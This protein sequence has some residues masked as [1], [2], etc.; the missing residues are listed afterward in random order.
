[1]AAPA[2]TLG[3]AEAAVDVGAHAA[4]SHLTWSV[5]AC[6]KP[7]PTISL[8][9]ARLSSVGWVCKSVIGWALN[10]IL[11]S[12]SLNITRQSCCG[13]NVAV[14]KTPRNASQD[15]PACSLC[16]SCSCY[17]C[18]SHLWQRGSSQWIHINISLMKV[19]HS[20]I[21]ASTLISVCNS[22]KHIWSERQTL[23]W[24]LSCSWKNP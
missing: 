16:Q 4:L 12:L 11:Q 6:L 17:S 13:P 23:V 19:K 18:F 20:Q 5:V 15:P 1:M 9:Q 21:S 7:P 22:W 8:S 2:P 14:W 24:T 3:C 10:M